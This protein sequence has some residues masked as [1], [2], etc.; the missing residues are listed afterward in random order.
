MVLVSESK[1][2]YRSI[3]KFILTNIQ[4]KVHEEF[5]LTNAYLY[6][7]SAKRFCLAVRRAKENLTVELRMECGTRPEVLTSTLHL[8]YQGKYETSYVLHLPPLLSLPV[9]H[10]RWN[11]P[12]AA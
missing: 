2:R 4:I 1:P 3:N 12:F 7:I 11:N 6:L 10:F 9:S 8:Q 5:L